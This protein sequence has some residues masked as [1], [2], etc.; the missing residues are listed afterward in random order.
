MSL[1]C[2]LF[3]K[4]FLG[5]DPQTPLLHISL[6]VQV[7]ILSY[8]LTSSAEHH[9]QETKTNY[10]QH[11]AGGRKY[12]YEGWFGLGVNGRVVLIFLLGAVT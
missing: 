4:I 1:F 2:T 3:S 8:I 7:G 12:D 9:F 10:I 5:E 11:I 6:P